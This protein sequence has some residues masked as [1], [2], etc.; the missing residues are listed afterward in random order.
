M[1][2]DLQLQRDVLAEL[3]AEPAIDAAKIEVAVGGGIVTLTGL[4]KSLLEK[5]TAEGAA[6][7][8]AGVKAVANEIDVKLPRDDDLIDTD[9]ASAVLSA[10]ECDTRAHYDR[11]KVTVEH[12]WVTLEGSVLWPFQRRAAEDV[13]R[14]TKGVREL[15]NLISVEPVPTPK[16]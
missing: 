14:H 16:V 13:A 8:V 3:Q 2:T 12:G 4:S 10:L 5:Y 11:I 9:L 6:L 15:T 7:R 1:Q